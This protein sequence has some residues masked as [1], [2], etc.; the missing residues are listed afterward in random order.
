MR[1]TCQEVYVV[2]CWG[3][4]YEHLTQKGKPYKYRPHPNKVIDRTFITHNIVSL[5]LQNEAKRVRIATLPSA[6]W[7]NELLL[8][9]AFQQCKV[10]G[11]YDGIEANRNAFR[12][13]VRNI[14]DPERFRA[15]QGLLSHHISDCRYGYDIIIADYLGNWLESKSSEL[16]LILRSESS[17][18][19][20]I[21]SVTFSLFRHTA[22]A[23]SMSNKMKDSMTPTIRR[24]IPV[25]YRRSIRGIIGDIHS[26]MRLLRIPCKTHDIHTYTNRLGKPYGTA[27]FACNEFA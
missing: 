23:R 16:E 27:I 9:Q 20:K 21:F 24:Y 6:S 10:K 11:L 3:M 19:L 15:Y 2:A 26:Q 13:M 18:T 17:D 22:Y 4:A 12:Q 8:D 1:N 14:P 25:K 7:S 5:V